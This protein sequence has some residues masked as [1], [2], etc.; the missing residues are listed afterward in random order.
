MHAEKKCRKIHAG[1]KPY[2]PELNR[3]GRKID[4]WRMIVKKKLGRNISTRKIKRAALAHDIPHIS[5][6]TLADC[7]HGRA[8]AYKKYFDYAKNAKEHR[9]NFLDQMTDEKAAEGN[10]K[11]AK[12]ILQTKLQEETRTVHRNVKLATKDF[13][14]APYQMELKNGDTS[15]ISADKDQLEQAMINKYEAKYRLARSSP[16]IHEPL[17][18]ALGPMALNENAQKIVQGTFVCPP[19]IKK[20]TKRFI[21]HLAMDEKIINNKP[22]RTRITTEESN[23]FWK[24]MKEKVSSSPSK[25]HI[26]TY[27]AAALHPINSVVQAEMMSLPYELGV[28][29]PRTTQCINASLMKKGERYYAWRYAHHLVDG[30][31]C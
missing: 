13:I 30:G 17:A 25:R 8:L 21:K 12:K 22:N 27:K 2:T 28:P 10:E 11:E 7:V 26:D 29:L 6:L 14:G 31:R 20:H 16:F 1:G 5:S 4:A 9:P 18:S 19:G 15:F 24:K 23:Q 3:L